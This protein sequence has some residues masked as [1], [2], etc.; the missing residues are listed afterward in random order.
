MLA[1]GRRSEQELVGLLGNDVK[2][3]LQRLQQEGLLQCATTG[4]T[5]E[6]DDDAVAGA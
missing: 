3:L 6:T 1:N 2:E 4:A 5:A